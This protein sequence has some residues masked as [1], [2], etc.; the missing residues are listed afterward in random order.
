MDTLD[1]EA[2]LGEYLPQL[3][4]LE[5]EDIRIPNQSLILDFFCIDEQFADFLRQDIFRPVDS[6]NK[7]WALVNVREAELNE[8]V[9]PECLEKL[10]EYK[11][12]SSEKIWKEIVYCT[13]K[14]Q[15]NNNILKLIDGIT[16][17][18][19]SI[20][21]QK[22]SQGL[23]SSVIPNSGSITSN[24]TSS[25]VV[26][27]SAQEPY[28]NEEGPQNDKKLANREPNKLGIVYASIS[29]VLLLSVILLATLSNSTTPV[30]EQQ[31]VP[32]FDDTDGLLKLENDSKDAVLICELRPLIERANSLSLSEKSLIDRKNKVV[33]EANKSIAFL[34]QRGA[35]G[36]K[37]W[38]DP[39]C[40]WGEQWY[41]QH[42][43]NGYRA[44]VA[45]SNKCINPK[46]HYEYWRD[47]EGKNILGKG[48][49]SLSGHRSG[50]ISIPYKFGGSTY[51]FIRNVSCG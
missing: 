5:Q 28:K 29:G 7:I 21:F 20:H 30:S 33:S 15:K 27:D 46:L 38:E 9:T 16:V 47:K 43:N 50:E 12:Q 1:L 4:L 18:S 3:A 25:S 10:L 51:M 11:G 17:N 13:A 19:S 35:R 22:G 2:R 6:R 24:L 8:I 14:H 41:D 39:A 32:S 45:L 34:D 23:E 31:P 37:Y 42:G 26:V 49:L 48:S 36:N 44:F 40:R